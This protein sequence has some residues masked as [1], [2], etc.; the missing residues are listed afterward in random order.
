[1][2]KPARKI[3]RKRGSQ[4]AR[5]ARRAVASA[6]TGGRGRGSEST[7]RFSRI[8]KSVK[9]IVPDDCQA[10][11]ILREVARDDSRYY[12]FWLLAGRYGR[13]AMSVQYKLTGDAAIRCDVP[14]GIDVSPTVLSPYLKK[15]LHD[16]GGLGDGP[17][18]II[19]K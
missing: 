12:A 19:G 15:F 14:R 17:P 9:V 1:M 3:A 2:D 18:I 13:D 5:T 7:P 16:E 4:P 11:L 6:P 8:T 10:S